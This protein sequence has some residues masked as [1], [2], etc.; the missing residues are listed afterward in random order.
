MADARESKILLSNEN[1]ALWLLPMKAKLH[2]MKVL[3]I[4]TGAIA[5]PDPEK[6]KPNAQLYQKYNE[7]AYVEIIQHLDQ[8]VLALV[9]TSLPPTDKFN[10]LAL[11]TLLKEKFAGNDLT[12]RTTA[13]K[14]FLSLE[15]D[16]FKTFLSSF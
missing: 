3:N 8:D 15:F 6:D 11:W 2:K 9:S 4:V 14:S 10:G 13:L 16:T 12:S 5:C 7:D 1:Y